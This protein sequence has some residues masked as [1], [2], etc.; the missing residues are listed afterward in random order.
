MASGRRFGTARRLPGPR[1]TRNA[2]IARSCCGS[3]VVEHSLGKGEVES[4]I[5]SRSTSH[6][7]D[8]RRFSRDCEIAVLFPRLVVY[9]IHGEP[10]L[11]SDERR[12]VVPQLPLSLKVDSGFSDWFRGQFT[13]TSSLCD[14]TS[15]LNAGSWRL[16][17]P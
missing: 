10:R 11:T 15:S 8:N 9:R 17:C 14:E 6:L 5:L 2:S 4:S 3:S 16:K 12:F 13:E 7:P 1:S